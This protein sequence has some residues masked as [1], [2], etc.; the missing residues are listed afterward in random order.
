MFHVLCLISKR[1]KKCSQFQG[2][3]IW[4]LLP[5]L[6]A[7]M[8][9]SAS[10]SKNELI[11]IEGLQEITFEDCLVIN[12][13]EYVI[14]EDLDYKELVNDTST[15]RP[16]CED[17]Q[18][19]YIDFVERS[20]LGRFTQVQGCNVSYIRELYADPDAEMYEYRIRIQVSGNCQNELSNMN[21]I[22]VPKLPDNYGVRYKVEIEGQ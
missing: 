7:I 19:P 17:F 6:A 3:K 21:W 15:S 22:S 12:Q 10:C 1:P 14:K 9:G 11:K 5:L 2:V 20:L 4:Y 13:S 16:G 18:L 8:L